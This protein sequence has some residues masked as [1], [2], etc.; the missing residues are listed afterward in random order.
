MEEYDVEGEL[1]AWLRDAKKIVVAG[2][3][4][5]LRRDDF[6]GMKIVK[7]MKG[8]V[9]QKV[10]LIECETVPESFIQEIVEFRPTHILVI[11][12]A[13]LDGSYGSVKLIK[14]LKISLPAISMHMLPLQIFFAYLRSTLGAKVALLAIQ[15]KITD[16]GEGLSREV[17]DSAKNLVK[18]LLKILSKI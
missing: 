10:Y 18:I 11:D 13:L 8:K 14:D 5:Q 6:A 16:F 1:Q 12:A 3:G 2:I 4:N 17:D 9:S 7:D 15:P